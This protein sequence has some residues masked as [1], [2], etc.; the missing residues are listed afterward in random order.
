MR[1]D[2]FWGEPKYGCANSSGLDPE[3]CNDVRGA[4]RAGLLVEFRVVDDLSGHWAPMFLHAEEDVDA[5]LN[6]AG[7]CQLRS[8]VRD[9]FPSD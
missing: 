6:Q 4:D 7:C 8:E 9:G 5:C 2:V 1:S 3:E